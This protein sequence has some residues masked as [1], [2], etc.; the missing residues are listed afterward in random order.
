MRAINVDKVQ[1][2][3]VNPAKNNCGTR[4]VASLV[5]DRSALRRALTITGSAVASASS[6]TP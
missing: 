5:T 1:N 6:R 4:L 3:K 2:V